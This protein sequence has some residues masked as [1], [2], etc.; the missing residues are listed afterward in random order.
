LDYEEEFGAIENRCIHVNVDLYS[1]AKIERK[2]NII[3]HSSKETQQA[4]K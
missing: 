4:C 1:R 3:N 2:I